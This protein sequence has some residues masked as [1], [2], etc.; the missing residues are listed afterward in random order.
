[1]GKNEVDAVS[2]K[3]VAAG[4]ISAVA[5]VRDDS[6]VSVVD[7]AVDDGRLA[8]VTDDDQ[9]SLEGDCV[10]S[11]EIAVE[12]IN[13]AAVKAI[14]ASGGNES[15]S[16]FESAVIRSIGNDQNETTSHRSVSVIDSKFDGNIKND[17]V[18]SQGSSIS[19]SIAAFDDF[20]NRLDAH[21]RSLI[22]SARAFSQSGSSM[23]INENGNAAVSLI[24][25]PLNAPSLQPSPS[26]AAVP[27]LVASSSDVNSSIQ[28][29]SLRRSNLMGSRASLQQPT[30]LLAPSQS[31][32]LLPKSSWAAPELNAKPLSRNVSSQALPFNFAVPASKAIPSS[33]KP[34]I[35][36][37]GKVLSNQ[38][39]QILEKS[40]MERCPSPSYRRG[41]LKVLENPLASSTENSQ[42]DHGLMHNCMLSMN[43]EGKRQVISMQTFEHFNDLR[44]YSAHVTASEA[45]DSSSLLQKSECLKKSTLAGS[46]LPSRTLLFGGEDS[47]ITPR[48]A[49]VVHRS[50]RLIHSAV[51]VDFLA[52]CEKKE[53]AVKDNIQPSLVIAKPSDSIP[54]NLISKDEDKIIAESAANPV[55]RPAL[56]KLAAPSFEPRIESRP[57]RKG[58][59]KSPLSAFVERT[60]ILSERPEK[61]D[62]Q[63]TE[64]DRKSQAFTVNKNQPQLSP[65]SLV[66]KRK[67]DRERERMQQAESKQPKDQEQQDLNEPQQKVTFGLPQPLTRV[68]DVNLTSSKILGDDLMKIQYKRRAA[69]LLGSEVNCASTCR[70]DANPDAIGTMASFASGMLLSGG[71]NSFNSL[72][73]SGDIAIN[74]PLAR[75]EQAASKSKSESVSESS[76][77]VVPATI[78]NGDNATA[79]PSYHPSNFP[80]PVVRRAQRIQEEE[81]IELPRTAN[82]IELQCIAATAAAPMSEPQ[83]QGPDRQNSRLSQ[84]QHEV[85]TLFSRLN[86]PQESMQSV[87]APLTRSLTV[88]VKE[89]TA[90]AV[91]SHPATPTNFK[92]ATEFASKYQNTM[93][94]PCREPEQSPRLTQGNRTC[95]RKQNMSSGNRSRDEGGL[96]LGA[97]RLLP[98]FDAEKWV[99][100]QNDGVN[101]Y[102]QRS[103]PVMS[104]I[105]DWEETH[106]E[107]DDF[108][109]I[110][111]QKTD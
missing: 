46:V 5:S 44:N 87:Q 35:S 25:R 77:I 84:S 21:R 13:E 49:G 18:A 106:N 100:R 41:P 97:P 111:I 56:A 103:S 60:N 52:E 105:G 92:G 89:K 37:A 86:G 39:P 69:I 51:T 1:M 30:P 80:A 40:P 88:S 20:Q 71:Q 68:N 98:E 42:L 94:L 110:P 72:N 79:T 48:A 23:K 108:S 6:L 107:T 61:V 54:R 85:T 102:T 14:S 31:A 19:E 26:F 29:S 101:K 74:A 27:T 50:P 33:S 57:V 16:L 17:D 90:S 83:S 3:S 4:H 104:Q 43:S 32:A 59:L 78:A 95:T 53:D 70:H 55:I 75:Q 15:Q 7:S 9:V 109:S 12:S 73:S 81:L 82:T 62:S 45:Q 36:T 64:E 99:R 28:R 93:T 2:E 47:S 10:V 66:I 11:E 91:I 67:A 76:S 24:S 63:P 8:K 22:E 58:A 65:N 38:F 34:F 96:T